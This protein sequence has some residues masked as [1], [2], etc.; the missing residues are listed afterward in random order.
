MPF[1]KRSFESPIYSP[2]ALEEK[3][4]ILIACEGKNTEF[5][6]FNGI[7]D[8]LPLKN[9]VNMEV[10]EREGNQANSS[11]PTKVVETLQNLD[12][13]RLKEIKEK[14]SF[15]D[16]YDVFWI[17]VD[18]EKQASK[19]KN[20]T[21]AIEIC[22]KENFNV[23]LVNPAFEF[24]LLLHVTDISKYDRKLLFENRKNR[25]K[26]RKRYL[27]LELSRILGGYDKAKLNST[28]FVSIEK[29]QLA[30]SQ[31]KLFQNDRERILY[32]LG[33]NLSKLLNE[34]ID[35]T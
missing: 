10:I 22:D 20:L 24:W 1:K 5:Q 35:I 8:T 30:V 15:E 7:K 32:E 13:N 21:K 25:S 12:E 26:T 11:A 2:Q 4:I 17:V 18:R 16:S 19:L 23:G 14:N 28:H 3:R 27:E 34:I 31:E 6:Y 29:I 33:S 9:L